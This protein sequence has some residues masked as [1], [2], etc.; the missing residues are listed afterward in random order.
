[1]KIGKKGLALICVFCSLTGGYISAQESGQD[2]LNDSFQPP[3]PSAPSPSAP[4]FDLP[5]TWAPFQASFMP[6]PGQHL[7]GLEKNIFGI[8]LSFV[9]AQ[10]MTSGLTLSIANLDQNSMGIN[11]ALAT[12]GDQLIGV[13]FS[14][15]TMVR[16]NQAVSI[17]FVQ[18]SRENMGM[19][20]G[21]CNLPVSQTKSENNGLQVGVLNVGGGD[22]TKPRKIPAGPPRKA[23]FQIGAFNVAEEGLQLGVFNY[24]RNALIPFTLIFNYSPKSQ[25]N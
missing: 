4:I 13:S 3:T 1:M 12:I 10:A 15:F 24:N 2:P 21:V 19:Q 20:V 18:F 6:G 16:V 25:S 22:R 11:V 9:T 14:P 7:F 8:N 23:L 17:A 5:G